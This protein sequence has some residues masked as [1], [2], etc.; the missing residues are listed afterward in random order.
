V[1]GQSA[2]SAAFVGRT[3]ETPVKFKR[4]EGH[5]TWHWKIVILS[6]FRKQELV[7]PDMECTKGGFVFGKSAHMPLHLARK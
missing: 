5:V 4:I 2:P 3:R 7:K 6:D 1:R